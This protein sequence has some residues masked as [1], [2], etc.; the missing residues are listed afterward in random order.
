MNFYQTMT[1]ILRDLAASPNL[2]DVSRES[3]KQWIAE[4]RN[5]EF[6]HEFERLFL[7]AEEAGISQSKLLTR[8][9]L[10]IEDIQFS[11]LP[12]RFFR[13]VPLPPELTQNHI[14]Q[15]MSKTE[16]MLSRINF[17]LRNS[18]DFPL[19]NFI[20]ANNFSGIVS[21]MLTDALDLS[22]PYK[23]NH[24]QRFPDLKNP[25]NGIGLELKAA[26]KPGKGGESHNGHGGWHLIA[27][28]ELDEVSG[29]IRFIHVEI[30]ELISFRDEPEGD[31]HYCG[32]SVDEETGSQRTET[33]Y[34]TNRG[35]SKLR[36]GSVYLDTEK[37]TNWQAWRHCQQY[38]I[39]PYSPLYFQRL[40]RDLPVPSL[41]N[42][43]KYS[44]WSAV[45]AQLNK[46]D[47]RWP[48]Y[49]RAELARLGIP[50]ELIAIIRPETA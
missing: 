37:V 47:A 9:S 30:A 5:W 16:Q 38:S 19:I 45:K 17:H 21:N 1:D 34:T 15:A 29:N 6:I 32:S 40:D 41:R 24:E 2:K 35:T 49:H 31:W 33:Y 39:P 43:E 3:V 48:L 46:I 36:D 22:S 8:L 18:A 13:H 4:G 11:P 23:H 28:F 14:Y 27:G 10:E 25:N 26:N 7:I 20:Q 44:K 50:S 12:E 42:P